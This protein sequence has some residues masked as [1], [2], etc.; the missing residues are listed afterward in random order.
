MTWLRQHSIRH[1]IVAPIW[2]RIPEKWRW[3]IV[4]RLD[5]SQRRCW[6][7]LVDAAL[8]Y[9][10]DDDAC[11]VPTP[12]GCGVGDCATT[13]YWVGGHVV[14]DHIGSHDCACYCGKFKFRAAEGGDDRNAP[15]PTPPARGAS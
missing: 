1:H 7:S 2:V 12:L 5:R 6:S 8:V 13:C 3:K 15:C 9:H 4:H 14:G 10:P 11:D